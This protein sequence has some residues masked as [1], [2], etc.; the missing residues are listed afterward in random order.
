MSLEDLPLEELP[1]LHEEAGQLQA[2]TLSDG[3]T[4]GAPTPAKAV[5]SGEFVGQT[6][7]GFRIE[8]TIGHGGAGAVFRARQL[9]LGRE[10][11]LKVLRRDLVGDPGKAR[12]R[13]IRESQTV[14]RLSHPHIAQ[15]L[16]AGTV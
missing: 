7:A 12:E 4:Q 15:A 5:E 14:A 3:P 10:V 9:S 2:P 13:M 8:G 6:L 16:D 1:T 11:A